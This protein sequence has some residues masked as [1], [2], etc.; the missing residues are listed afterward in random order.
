MIKVSATLHTSISVT[1]RFAKCDGRVQFGP[2]VYKYADTP[3]D[4]ANL[5]LNF[6]FPY[7]GVLAG[8]EYYSLREDIPVYI[9]VYRPVKHEE[10]KAISRTRLNTGRVGLVKYILE[11]VE[12]FNVKKGDFI[13]IHYDTVINL[14]GR[15]FTVIPYATGERWALQGCSN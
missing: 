5:F 15:D 3:D 14:K 2:G 13:G 9:A 8:W 12:R 6:T 10:Y 1:D 4:Q 11:D 7:D